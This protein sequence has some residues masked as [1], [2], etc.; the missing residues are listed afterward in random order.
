MNFARVLQERR[1]D[2]PENQRY[3]L[4]KEIMEGSHLIG[5]R[6]KKTEQRNAHFIQQTIQNHP[7]SPARD[8]LALHK[9]KPSKM[10]EREQKDEEK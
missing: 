3:N 8:T 1:K 2:Q 7:T 9:P 5:G 10:Q 4:Y 6:T